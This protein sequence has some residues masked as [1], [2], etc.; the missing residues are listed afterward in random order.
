MLFGLLAA[1]IPPA[2]AQDP[3]PPLAGTWGGEHV[4]FESHNGGATLEFD[5]AHGAILDAIKPDAQGEFTVRGTFTAEHGG[6]IRRDNPPRDVPAMY[7]GTIA[8]DVMHLTITL[9]DGSKAMEELTLTRGQDG[10]VRKC[11]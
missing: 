5:C 9:S 4:A 1:A 3:P 8:G 2:V 11:R 7:K 6:P 10:V